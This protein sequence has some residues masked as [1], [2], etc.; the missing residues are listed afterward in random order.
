MMN[1]VILT[2]R[3]TK[4]P[5]LKKTNSGLS[6][7]Q[8]NLAVNRNYVSKSGER[9]ADFINC[10]VWRVQADN[11][12]KYIKKGGLIGV[13]GEIQTRT[14]DDQNGIR[15]YITE[16][17]CNSIEFLEPKSQQSKSNYDPFGDMNQ[18]YSYNDNSSNKNNKVDTDPFK[19]IQNDLNL[20]DDDL[21][22]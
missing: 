3:L 2:G 15:K 9:Q 12:A 17:V 4:D 1:K 13:E 19:D 14:Y 7:V 5:E 20:S 16:V 6:Y 21:P 22:F 8:F 18:D 10:V 11:L